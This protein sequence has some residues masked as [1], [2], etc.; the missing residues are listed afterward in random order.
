MEFKMDMNIS[1]D[2]IWLNYI[3]KPCINCGRN[4]VEISNKGRKVCEKCFMDQDT[5][6]YAIDRLRERR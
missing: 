2:E 4:R 6:K 5:G 1:D 3:S